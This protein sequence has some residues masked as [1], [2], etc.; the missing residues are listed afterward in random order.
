M[1][2][3]GMAM[4]QAS[5]SALKT[6]WLGWSFLEAIPFDMS[7]SLRLTASFELIQSPACL[8]RRS[9]TRRSFCFWPLIILQSLAPVI[10]LG[11]FVNE[12]KAQ[13]GKKVSVEVADELRTLVQ[14]ALA[15]LP[16]A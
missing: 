3:T 10:V 15:A 13:L 4:L 8:G 2:V 16:P 12:L 1:E 5:S 11:A 7:G 14:L 9:E 6:N